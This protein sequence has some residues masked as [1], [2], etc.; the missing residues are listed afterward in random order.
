MPLRILI[1]ASTL[2]FIAGCESELERCIEADSTDQL[3]KVMKEN[4]WYDP[5]AFSSNRTTEEDIEEANK[6]AARV[7]NLQGIY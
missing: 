1:I 2:I 5:E 4:H 3:R 7:C 6:R